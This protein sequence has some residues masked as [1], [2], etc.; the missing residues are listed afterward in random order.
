MA[1]PFNAGEHVYC[2]HVPSDGNCYI[3]R[4]SNLVEVK[5][6][7]VVG[8]ITVTHRPIVSCTKKGRW[9]KITLKVHFKLHSASNVA[10]ITNNIALKEKRGT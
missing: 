3:L 10:K 4:K 8:S 1:D 7:P 6:H 5:W 9:I 2:V